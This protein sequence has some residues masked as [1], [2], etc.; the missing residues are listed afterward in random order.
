[1]TITPPATG[2]CD[3][4]RDALGAFRG[5]AHVT[6]RW[7][8][9]LAAALSGGARLLA[10]GNGGSAAQAQHLTAELVGRYREDRPP[11]S[12]IALHAD[13][14]STTAIANDYGVDE[15]FAR[16]VRAHGRAGDVLML[17]STSGAS[18]NLL[19]AASAARAAGVRV[20]ALT[21][22][23]PNPLMAGSDESLCVEAPSTATVQEIHLVAVHMVCA[24][25][26]AAVAR[27]VRAVRNG[28]G[29]RGRGTRR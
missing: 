2:H 14:S 9:G 12:A 22:P 29:T 7:G 28:R 1:M 21:G 18:A 20:W 13:T 26:D 11:F 25:F 3:R 5:S 10:A 16:Q 8:E 4:L 19:S 17:L 24:A 27:G 23:A 15:V 6:E